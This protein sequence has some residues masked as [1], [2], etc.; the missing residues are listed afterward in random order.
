MSEILRY[1]VTGT[2]FIVGCLI[3]ACLIAHN[4]KDT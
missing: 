3:V 4:E 2:V 1:A